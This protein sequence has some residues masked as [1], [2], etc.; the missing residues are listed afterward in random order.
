MRIEEPSGVGKDGS[1]EGRRESQGACS[2]L[3]RR[4]MAETL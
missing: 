3:E 4:E 2:K 1:W